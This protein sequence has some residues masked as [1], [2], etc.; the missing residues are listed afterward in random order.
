[1]DTD[2]L[3]LHNE[4]DVEQKLL[5]PL[6]TK[7]V[8]DGL[9]YDKTDVWTKASNRQFPIGKGNSSK[10]YF[11][12]Y[13]VVLAGFPVLILE[14]KPPGSD[15]QKALNE[16]RL[17]ANELNALFEHNFNPC[18]FTV[19][20]NG[21]ELC[22]SKHDQ[23]APCGQLAITSLVASS[24]EFAELL[25][26]LAKPHVQTAVDEFRKVG[27]ENCK[28]LRP[29]S[30]V[31]GTAF[32]SQE[33]PENS[34]GSTIAGDYR[35]IF[36]PSSPAE[37]RVVA[38]EAYIASTRRLRYIEPIDRMIRN[39]VSPSVRSLRVLK[40]SSNPQE[41][42]STLQDTGKLENQMLLIVGSV[43]AGKSTFVDYLSQ[44]ALPKDIRDQSVWVRIDL[45]AA[46]LDL[47]TAYDWIDKAIISGL[48]QVFSDIDFDELDFLMRVFSIE[49][50]AEVKG[51]LALLDKDS[52]EYKV[53]LSDLLSSLLKNTRAKAQAFARYFSTA[54]NRLLVIVLDNCDKRNTEEQL[55]MFQVANWIQSE[56][57]CLTILPIRDVTYDLHRDTPPLDTALKN[58]IFRIEPPPF[59]EVLAQR[60]RLAL[61]SM[62]SDNNDARPLSYTLPNSIRVTY[63]AKDQ[64]LFLVSI[65]RSLYAHDKLVRQI[66]TGIAGRDVRRAL[67]I[68]ARAGI[69]ARMKFWRFGKAK[70]NTNFRLIWLL[71][72][73]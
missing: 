16:A 31:G 48:Q 32:Q 62:G 55:T 9:G 60:V 20:C 19:A 43:G 40:D 17:Y 15:L 8:P 52:Q 14:A 23:Q 25:A 63:K 54:G 33:L 47:S 10:L 51:P 61:Q 38:K 41:V 22:W 44:V 49:I 65:M 72:S 39:A 70:G 36:N 27:S 28:F 58:H 29:V 71:G 73:Y 64:S 21:E 11:P 67:E 69:L 5:F 35:H 50:K 42:I 37:R 66:I 59:H 18:K 24:H 68:F 26:C 56:Y 45:N 2:N 46:P 30:L 13:I 6:L 57:R 4:S 53:R 34:F 3:E 7:G 12:D 1:M